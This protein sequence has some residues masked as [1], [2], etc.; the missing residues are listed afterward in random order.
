MALDPASL[1]YRAWTRETEMTQRDR[2][3]QEALSDLIAKAETAEQW[4]E[5][6]LLEKQMIEAD[7]G[8]R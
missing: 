7:H 6:C 4:A 1:K 2:K 8:A 3:I 5:V